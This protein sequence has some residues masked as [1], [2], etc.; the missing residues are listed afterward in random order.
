M[1][2]HQD[3]Q[4]TDVLLTDKNITSVGGV[5]GRRGCRRGAVI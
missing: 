4:N 5:R 3:V 1:V 2:L